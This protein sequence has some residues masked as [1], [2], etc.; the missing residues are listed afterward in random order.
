MEEELLDIVDENN[1]LIGEIAPR[2]KIHAEGIWHRT[3]HI[4]LFRKN[5]GQIDFLV[6]LRAPFKDLNPNKWGTSFAGHIKS[7]A[8]IE[9]GVKSELQEE[10][11]LDIDFEKLLGGYWRKRDK[12]LNREFTMTY[13][14]EYNGKLEDLKFNDGEVQEV[15]WMSIEDIR[16]SM[17]EDPEKWA[18]KVA[19]FIKTSDYLKEII[20]KKI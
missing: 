3:V 14:Y 10:I 4:F 20:N 12:G 9:E 15:K 2:S 11:G 17:V 5:N 16:R 19:G 6:Q 7:G 1:N 18:G 8:T 13:F